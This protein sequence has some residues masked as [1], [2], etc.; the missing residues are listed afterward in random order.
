L[1]FA[2]WL[3]ISKLGVF[4]D[5]AFSYLSLLFTPLYTI[6]CKLKLQFSKASV[7]FVSLLW[8]AFC[9]V[10][11][12]LVAPESLVNMILVALEYSVTVIL[13]AL[14]YLEVMILFAL[15]RQKYG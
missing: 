8:S 12:H 7:F 3:N 1:C 9:D 4:N 13:F 11:V 2:K 5:M 15:N 6:F 10:I 14:K